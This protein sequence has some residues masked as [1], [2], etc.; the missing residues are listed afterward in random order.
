MRRFEKE[1]FVSPQKGV[2]LLLLF[3][4]VLMWLLAVEKGRPDCLTFLGGQKSFQE[5]SEN[6]GERIDK[7]TK[8]R[9]GDQ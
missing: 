5:K 2:E 6:D 3:H 9:K 4:Q 8:K 7:Q 1:N